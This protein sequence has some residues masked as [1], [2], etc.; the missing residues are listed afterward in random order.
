[1]YTSSFFSEFFSP[2]GIILT[3]VAVLIVLGV[4]LLLVAVVRMNTRLRY[5]T[6]PVYD[7]IVKKAERKAT[8]ILNTA[9]EKRRDIIT[10]AEEAATKLLTDKRSEF[11]KF[12]T[13]YAEQFSELAKKGSD[14]LAAQ[15]EM[16]AHQSEQLTEIVKK[17]LATTDETLGKEQARF[18]EVAARAA[19]QFEHSF[20][21]LAAQ[22]REEQHARAAEMQARVVEGIEKEITE[23]KNAIAVYRK[24][25]MA[26]VDR[27]SISLVTET[28]RI[29]LGKTLSFEEHRDIILR[30]LEDAKKSGIFAV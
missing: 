30:A 23:T 8:D 7:E 21:D 25:R 17:H 18:G 26:L 19:E 4:S 10:A 9:E 11:E 15:T 22:A 29:V 24:E 20:A 1:M 5:L 28:T 14:A 3:V 2:L 27:N 13:E 6:Y 12:H 16:I